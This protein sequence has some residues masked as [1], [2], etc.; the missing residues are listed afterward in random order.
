VAITFAENSA[1][2]ST[3]EY[4]LPNNSTTLTPQTDDCILQIWLDV[5]AMAAGDEYQIRLYEKVQGGGTQRIAW[6][7]NLVG[8]Q[9]PP[10]WVS[11]SFILGNGWDVTM[12][13]IAGTDRTIVWS[14]RKIT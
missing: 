13:K 8:A 6:Q 10:L 1:S 5:N 14:L 2:I 4:S 7:S 12:D 3:T 11:P 9:S